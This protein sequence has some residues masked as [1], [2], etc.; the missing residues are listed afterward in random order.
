MPA[1]M[2]NHY[3]DI[4]HDRLGN[5]PAFLQYF[6]H[7]VAKCINVHRGRWE[8][9]WA[10]GQT[11]LVLLVEREDVIA[12]VVYAATNPVKDHLV[13]KVHHW[14]GINGLSALLNDRPMVAT[15]PAYFFR[16][17]GPMPETATLRLTIPAS[18]GDPTAFREEVR[19][20]CAEVEA[21]AA[22]ERRETGRRIRS[23]PLPLATR[24]QRDCGQCRRS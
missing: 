15:R 6:H 21:E 23:T 7:L 22:R 11:S 19:R 4:V 13:E 2:S 8:N 3:H 14:P 12:K 1:M 24:T 5:I 10:V 20:R 17:D 16:D 9:V 18:L